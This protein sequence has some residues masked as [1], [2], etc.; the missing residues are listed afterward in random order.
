[1]Q[2]RRGTLSY[3]GK[4]CRIVGLRPF[5]YLAARESLRSRYLPPFQTSKL[6]AVPAEGSHLVSK[7]R[8]T[9]ILIASTC[10]STLTPTLQ[11]VRGITCH[12][13]TLHFPPLPPSSLGNTDPRRILEIVDTVLGLPEQSIVSQLPS[14]S[15]SLGHVSRDR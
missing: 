4:P 5:I 11:G 1:M 13:P 10:G 8:R 12:R 15:V 7:R 9:V 3:L 2:N 6:L 14:S